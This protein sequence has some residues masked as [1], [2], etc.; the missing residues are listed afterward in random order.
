MKKL[1]FIMVLVILV[2]ALFYCSNWAFADSLIIHDGAALNLND[3]MLDLNCL[4]LTIEDG[5][6]LDLGTG[7][8]EECGALQVRSGGVLILIA[9]TMLLS[10]QRLVSRIT[11]T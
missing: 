2:G 4:D 7:T 11:G 10:M 8:V 6:T 1:R 3:A 5:G 9:S